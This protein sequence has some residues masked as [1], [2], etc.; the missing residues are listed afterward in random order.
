[1]GQR[2]QATCMGIAWTLVLT[3]FVAAQQPAAPGQSP[4]MGAMMQECQTH[5]EMTTTAIDQLTARLKEAAESND[6]AQMRTALTQVQQ[7]LTEMK[8]HI[9]MC[10]NSL[11][12]TFVSRFE[13]S[14]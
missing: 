5:C 7:P 10:R 9:G 6:P 3:A 8:E 13:M 14:T 2:V 11:P 12:D 4:S 1:M